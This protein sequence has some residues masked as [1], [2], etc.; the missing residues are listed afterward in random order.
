MQDRETVAAIAAGDPQGLAE[1]YDHYAAPLY[2]YCRFMLPGADPSDD[3][4]DAVRDTFIIAT[5]RLQGLRDPDRLGCWLQAV[6]RNECLRRLSAGGGAA[7]LAGRPDSDGPMPEVTL[8]AGLREQV[9]TAC[10]DSTPAGRAC[11][12][13][14]THRAGSFGRTGFPKPVV[15][16]GPRWSQE[17]RQHPRAAAGVAAVAAAVA[18]AGIVATLMIGGPHRAPAP[19]LGLGG[20]VSGSSGVASGAVPSSPGKSSSPGHKAG[21]AKGTPTSSAPE[22]GPNSSQDTAAG[23]PKPT[24]PAPSSSSSGSSPSPSASP[25][26]ALT[27]SPSPSPSPRRGILRAA[28]ARLALTAVKG[29][30]ATGTFILTAVGGPVSHYVIKVPAKLAT[31]VAVSPSSGSLK[32]AGAWVG[33]TVTVKSRVSLHTHLTVN[34][35]GR[36]ITVLL[37]IKG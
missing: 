19:A 10:T 31:K 18:A 25:T 3:A 15:P 32:S 37:T 14:V 9:L 13:S 30:A 21:D 29:K 27:S 4:A 16:P 23:K 36:V 8:P 11:R 12:V 20:G 24:T 5:S 35:G 26:P 7:R 1:A 22:D 2:T 33:V 17:V 6:A 28:P 34:P